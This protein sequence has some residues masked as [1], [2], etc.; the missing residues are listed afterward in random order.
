MR[1]AICTSQGI[2]VAML[3]KVVVLAR[4][5]DVFTIPVTS[6]R[7]LHRLLGTVA[8]AIDEDA[9]GIAEERIQTPSADVL[10][11]V[12]DRAQPAENGLN[13]SARRTVTKEAYAR[14]RAPK[15]NSR[16][17]RIWEAVKQTLH[18]RST[19][20]PYDELLALVASRALTS[21]NPNHALRICLGKKLSTGELLQTTS[22]R[23]Y[24]DLK[25]TMP[26][27][28]QGGRKTARNRPGKLW[29]GIREYL[30]RHPDG[31]S[32]RELVT[33]ASEQGWTNATQVEHAVRICLAR[34]S[35]QIEQ[36]PSGRYTL[37]RNIPDVPVKSSIVRRRR[38]REAEAKPEPTKPAT[39]ESNQSGS[40]G[41]IDT[42]PDTPVFVAS[43]FYP[44]R[45]QRG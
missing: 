37:R 6:L 2:E 3:D 17:G 39:K 44:R 9:T 14:G 23:Y 38:P 29:Q 27:G 43:S 5:T 21:K 31:L 33:A 28:A 30:A 19:P 1:R 15:P 7:D 24:L 8:A 45:K 10:S 34:V 25:S 12:S 20:I 35:D 13:A 4:G 32:E 26:A 11:E 42:Q 41:T 40:R 36:L 16:R 18:E 22:G